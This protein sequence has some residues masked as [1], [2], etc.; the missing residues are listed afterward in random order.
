MHI[1]R[2]YQKQAKRAVQ[3]AWSRGKRAPLLRMPTGSGKTTVV[4]HL[5]KDYPS[6]NCLFLCPARELVNQGVKR[7]REHG[8]PAGA[9]MGRQRPK[10]GETVHVATVQTAINR[11]LG[12]YALI[13]IDEAHHAVAKQCKT[14]LAKYPKANLLGITATPIRL[15]GKGLGTIFDELL[16]PIELQTLIDSGWLVPLKVFA[17]TKPVNLSKVKVDRK[18]RD[19]ATHSLMKHYA[20]P[21]LVGDAVEHWRRYAEHR[22]TFVYCCS[23]VHAESTAELLRAAGIKTGVITGETGKTARAEL[24]KAMQ[25]GELTALCNVGVLTEGVDFPRLGCI[26]LLRPTLSKA[27]HF[28]ILGR[29]H[30]TAPNKR[31]CIILDHADN[32]RRHGFPEEPQKWSL[33]GVRNQASRGFRKVTEPKAI[34]CPNCGA[35]I[36]V[37]SVEC[38][39]C[40]KS[41]LPLT[42]TGVLREISPKHHRWRVFW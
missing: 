39:N 37:L 22:P 9:M 10:S 7:F 11:D 42:G 38:P 2:P 30:R 5:I 28:Q 19:F 18:K 14:L 6:K 32:F 25:G 3:G 17:P 36:P 31:D 26:M 4:A 34:E 12:D 15:D 8:I 29:G 40:G 1:L 20:T 13:V 24:F 21:K 27:L 23:I 41:I 35:L 33:A 16:D